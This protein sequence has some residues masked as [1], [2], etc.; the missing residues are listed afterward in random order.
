MQLHRTWFE[1][2]VTI[3]AFAILVLAAYL[4]AGAFGAFGGELPDPELTPGACKQMT[5]KQL[6]STKWGRDKRHVTVAMKMEVFH[7][8]GLSGNRDRSCKCARH[9]EIDHLCSRELGGLDVVSNLWPQ[10]YC[11]D[12]N[13]VMKDR[14]ENRLHKEVCA[15]NIT[16]EQAQREITGDWRVP[17]RRYFGEP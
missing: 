15:G 8:Y 5:L 4:V 7:A 1:T 3:G 6:C 2:T 14:V 17:Y 12:Y 9:F 16:L 11:G 13:A 10:C